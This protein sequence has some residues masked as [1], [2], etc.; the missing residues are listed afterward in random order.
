MERTLTGVNVGI[1]NAKERYFKI[2]KEMEF[3]CQWNSSNGHGWW[4]WDQNIFMYLGSVQEA[5]MT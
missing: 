1:V 2:S 3:W 5:D 4:I